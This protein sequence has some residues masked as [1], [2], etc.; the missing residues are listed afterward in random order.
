MG[1]WN[2]LGFTKEEQKILSLKNQTKED[3]KWRK[4]IYQEWR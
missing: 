3:A 1:F 4:K 2:K